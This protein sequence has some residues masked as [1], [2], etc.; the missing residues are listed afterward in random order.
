MDSGEEL[1]W[2]SHQTDRYRLDWK[3]TQFIYSLPQV[4]VI[5]EKQIEKKEESVA[6]KGI[7]IQPNQPNPLKWHGFPAFPAFPARVATLSQTYTSLN[8]ALT[9]KNLVNPSKWNPK[10][11]LIFLFRDSVDLNHNTWFHNSLSTGKMMINVIIKNWKIG[12]G[13]KY[14]PLLSAQEKK[15]STDKRAHTQWQESDSAGEKG[16]TANFYP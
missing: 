14:S 2:I 6:Q 4:S 12:N 10:S 11:S 16:T 3:T 13:S 1:M 7:K 9:H 5:I 8:H 15:L